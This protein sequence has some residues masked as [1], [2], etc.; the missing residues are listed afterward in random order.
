MDGLRTN[1]LP[2]YISCTTCTW[3]GEL[4]EEPKW[5]QGVLKHLEESKEEH[6][7]TVNQQDKV[8]VWEGKEHEGRKYR[9]LSIS[10]YSKKKY[11]NYTNTQE[12]L[13]IS[14]VLVVT[15][16]LIQVLC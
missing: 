11:K 6:T 15:F 8:L 5:L 9:N 16:S 4:V 2:Y 12:E 3:K 1:L 10:Q 13:S 14:I 7:R